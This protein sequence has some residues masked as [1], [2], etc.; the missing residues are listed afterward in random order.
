MLGIN[1]RENLGSMMRTAAALGIENLLIGPRTAD[2]F[3]RR[4]IRVS[5]A[6]VLKQQLYEL[7]QPADQLAR[8]QRT[9]DVRTIITTLDA[10]ATPLDKFEPDDR[11]M[12][13]VVGNEAEGVDHATQAIATDRV[14]IP[15]QLGTDSLNVAV[16]AAIIMYQLLSR[17]R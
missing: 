15:M 10:G 11:K 17:H 2:P 8:L 16:A 6:T 12:V 4:T 14:T 1:Q 3:S 7:D 13:L 5:M 9:R